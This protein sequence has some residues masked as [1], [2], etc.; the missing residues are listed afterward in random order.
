MIENCT[1]L[2]QPSNLFK[3][4]TNFKADT[5]ELEHDICTNNNL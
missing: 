3:D 5:N 4:L 1:K 2:E